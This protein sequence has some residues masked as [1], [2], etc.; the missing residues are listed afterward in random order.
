MADEKKTTLEKSGGASVFQRFSAWLGTIF[1]TEKPKYE[2]HINSA[3][4]EQ[5]KYVE[6]DKTKDYIQN[7]LLDQI[8]Y[9][10]SSSRKSKTNYQHLMTA[11]I[12]IGAAIPVTAVFVNDTLPIKLLIA[13]LGAAVTAIN[14]ILSMQNYRDLWLAHRGIRQGLERILYFY[15][16][17]VGIFSEGTRDEKDARLVSICEGELN[18]EIEKWRSFI[19]KKSEDTNDEK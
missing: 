17:N 7:R 19:R 8:N 1:S 10:A 16:N 4:I 18:Q 2:N 5:L 3:I 6:N 14:A 9:Y 11:S 15:F 12:V 13:F